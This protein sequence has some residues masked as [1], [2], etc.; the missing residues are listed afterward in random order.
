MA[1]SRASSSW[2]SHLRR[3]TSSGRYI[4][5]VDGIRFVAIAAVFVYHVGGDIVRHSSELSNQALEG[6]SVARLVFGLNVGVQ[7]FFVL[8][9]FILGL[10]FAGQYLAGASPVRLKRYLARRL[11]RL[12][13]PYVAALCLLLVLKLIGRRGTFGELLPHFAASLFYSHNLV[14]GRPSDINF[15]AWSLEIEIQF[16]LLAPLLARLLFGI[17]G[18]SVRRAGIALLCIGIGWATVGLPPE[19][20]WQLSLVGQ[21]PYFLAGLLLADVY[22]TREQTQAPHWGWDVLCAAAGVAILDARFH[23]RAWLF[24]RPVAIAACYHGALRGAWFRRVLAWPPFAAIGGMCYSI[25]LLHNYIVAL[26]GM[27]TERIGATLPFT[28]RLALQATVMAVPVLLLSTVFYLLIERPCMRPDWPSRLQRRLRA[29]LPNSGELSASAEQ[30]APP[31]GE[32][33]G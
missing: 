23:S 26:C 20:I 28:A 5:E 17:R 30:P 31:K 27:A 11:T 16:Y 19:S 2:L 3:V 4:P 29:W 9:G 21:A 33:P 10:P 1:S 6:D 12:E 25:Y 32:E 24:L 18:A 14:F 7:L 8:S 22:C 15:A 13:P